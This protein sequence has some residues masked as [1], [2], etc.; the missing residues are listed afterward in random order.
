MV[1][2]VF[3]QGQ[4]QGIG[5]SFDSFL[6]R[7]IEICQEQ[8]QSDRAKAFA[9]IFYDFNDKATKKVLKN[10]GGFTRLDHLSGH[11]LSVFYL[12]SDN[13]KQLRTFNDTFLHVFDIS[14]NRPLPF[15]LFFKLADRDAKDVEIV[16]LEQ[17]N[18]MFAFDELYRVIENYVSKLNN[19][20]IKKENNSYKFI[21]IIQSAKTIA[22]KAFIEYLISES[23]QYGMDKVHVT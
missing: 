21:H 23:I 11:D 6:R 10:R 16:E 22:V 7:F 8:L 9:F 17:S 1:P 12:D 14:T 5:H 18:I 2:I 19:D 15:V 13:K 4:C 3:E 20:D